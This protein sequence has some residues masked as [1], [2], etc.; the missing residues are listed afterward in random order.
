MKKSFFK[1]IIL[2]CLLAMASIAAGQ[3]DTALQNENDRLILAADKGDTAQVIQLI[4]QGADVNTA[5]WEGVTSLMYACQN[6]DMAM[7]RLLLRKGAKPDLKPFNGYT[8]LIASIRGGLYEVVELLIRS[9]ADINLADNDKVTP[10]M[11]AISV[12]SFYMPDILLYYEADV[13]LQDDEGMDALMLASWLGRY[14]I[15][16]SLIEGGADVNSTDSKKRTPLHYA[17]IAGHQII[18]DLL[19]GAGAK[20]ESRTSAGY[21]PLSVAASL[22]KYAASRL[23]IGY[24]ADV[25]SRVNCSL[26]PM[27]I[28]IENKNDSLVRMLKNNG[29]T[30]IK[31]PYFNQANMGAIVIFNSRDIFTGLSLGVID[32][33]YNIGIGMMYVFRPKAMQ[34]LNQTMDTL[35]FQYWEKRHMVRLLQEK[36]FYFSPA[37]Q[38][39]RIGLMAGIGETLTFGNYR[40]SSDHPDVRFLLNPRIG[41]VLNIDFLRFRLDYEFTDL[42]LEDVGKG[43]LSFSME[44]LF[45]QRNTLS[46][47]SV[48]GL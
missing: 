25:N 42:R 44:F 37:T 39:F 26:N 23:L 40:G 24:G 16:A 1:V 22:D 43:W 35:Y 33:K 7:I 18:M 34:V 11:H 27:T 3:E 32:K 45:R 13:K 5:T 30:A 19:I 2:F 41:T 36:A 47:H 48:H 14:E 12:D 4:G 15:A 8:A 38:A 17:T 20:L 21:T 46:I 9:G 10:L 6:D 31:W 28:A 29:A